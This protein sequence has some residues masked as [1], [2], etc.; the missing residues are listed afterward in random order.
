[1]PVSTLSHGG[2]YATDL[3]QRNSIVSVDIVPEED[4][5]CRICYEKYG[6][7]NHEGVIEH[8]FMLYKC[9]HIFGSICIKKW[10]GSER[11]TTCPLCRCKCVSD[12]ELLD[13]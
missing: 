1:M 7:P 3:P 9:R 5:C 2:I 12:H 10:F 13:Y 6:I 4:R 11:K 8:P